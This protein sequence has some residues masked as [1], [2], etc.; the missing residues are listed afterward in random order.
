MIKLFKTKPVH[1]IK[2][3]KNCP[4]KENEHLFPNLKVFFFVFVK[5]SL[6]SVLPTFDA[7]TQ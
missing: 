5:F 2:K 1:I 7:N 6:I 4:K 3:L